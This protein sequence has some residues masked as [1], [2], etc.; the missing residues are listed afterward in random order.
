MVAF[1]FPGQGSQY[2]G[3]G[4]ALFEADPKVRE[5]FQKAEDILELPLSDICFAG[6][7]EEL[8][9]TRIAQPAL[10]TVGAAAHLYLTERGVHPDLAFGH[11]LGEFTALF[12]AGA[13]SFEAGL[14]LVRRRGELMSEA[15]QKHPGTMAAIIGL[16]Q[17]QVERILR[18][19]GGVVEIANLN[20]PEQIVIS[21]EVDAVERAMAIA[22][23]EGA[24]RVVRLKV[25]AA[26]HS[27]L[28]EEAARKFEKLIGE[29]EIQKP[30]IPVILNATA[31]LTQDPEVIREA[32]KMQ[33][34]SPVR[35]VEMLQK[36]REAGV[37]TFVEVGPGRVLQ[38]LVRR[39]L[40][41]AQVLGFEK[42]E[43]FEPLR[44]ALAPG[45]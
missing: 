1:M 16:S 44:T 38:G 18:A 12:A 17:E 32:L 22:Q 7:L 23:V 29:A 40:K 36:A 19:A 41:G 43:Q 39:T 5:L 14:R 35:F 15:G 20:T 9:E 24:R 6:P 34:R 42:P 2:V 31:E 37:E 13:F 10:Y 11:S 33:L 3:M 30:R 28:M 45:G 27:P 25:S 8:T 4:Q 26:F 21:G